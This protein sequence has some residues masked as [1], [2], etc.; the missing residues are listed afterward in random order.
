MNCVLDKVL[1]LPEPPSVTAPKDTSELLYAVA[2]QLIVAELFVN[3]A[4]KDIRGLAD[5]VDIAS[6]NTNAYPVVFSTNSVEFWENTT[7]VD[8]DEVGLP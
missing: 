6:S 2:A 5:V 4:L 1:V 8:Q 3:E 7:G